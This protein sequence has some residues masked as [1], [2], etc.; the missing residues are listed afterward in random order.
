MWLGAEYCPHCGARAAAGVD[1][2]GG[3]LK[4]PGCSSD[5]P[6]I[7][8]GDVAMH[9]CASCDSIW[10]D[11]PTFVKLCTDQQARGDLVTSL[12]VTSAGESPRPASTNPVRYVRCPACQKTMNRSN[13]GRASGIVIDLCKGHG[14]W[15][16]HGELHGVLQF[17]ASGGLDRQRS[18]DGSHADLTNATIGMALLGDSMNG[19]SSARMRLVMETTQEDVIGHALHGFL[20]A[21]LG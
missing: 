15:F 5:M 20:N 14:A 19:Q 9:R 1:A 16:E 8:V 11:P 3:T 18:V 12:G 4:C 13:F 21:L 6:H 17:V 10:L 2:G 7:R